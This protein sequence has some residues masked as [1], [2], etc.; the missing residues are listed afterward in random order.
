MIKEY[1][2]RINGYA[3][4]EGKILRLTIINENVYAKIDDSLLA[5]AVINII[6][7]C[8]KYAKSEVIVTI[9]SEKNDVVIKISDDGN[10]IAQNDLPHIFDRFYKGKQG[11]FGLGLS[12][13]L[14]AV[15]FMGGSVKAYNEG[16]AVFEIRFMLN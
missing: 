1:V 3:I 15:E 4:K 16:G 7:N 10:G 13:A 6:S 2:Q 9:Y 12:I 5:Q 11:N 14:S 8:I